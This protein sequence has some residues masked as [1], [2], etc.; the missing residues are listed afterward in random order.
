MWANPPSKIYKSI[1]QF[2]V[3]AKPIVGWEQGY[4]KAFSEALMNGKREHW[5]LCLSPGIDL[6]RSHLG[7]ELGYQ[8]I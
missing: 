2:F 5:F 3:H 7:L 6:E 8:R 1:S 4:L